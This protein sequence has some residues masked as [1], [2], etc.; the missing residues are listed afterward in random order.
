MQKL[1]V[2]QYGEKSQQSVS[3]ANHFALELKRP[4]NKVTFHNCVL[5]WDTGES[6]RLTPFHGDFIDYVECWLPVKNISKTNMV[7]GI[8]TTLH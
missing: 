1:D 7:I 4:H 6:L 8:G 5:I 2:K 3:C